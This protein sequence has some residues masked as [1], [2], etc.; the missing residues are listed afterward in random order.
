M[1]GI[2]K[3]EAWTVTR[4]QTGGGLCARSHHHVTQYELGTAIMTKNMGSIDRAVR[5][6][7][8]VV[9]IA[10]AATGTVGWWGYIGIV[11]LVTAIVGICPGLLAVRHQDLQARR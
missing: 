7:V 2:R 4:S 11:P 10:L 5:A 9:L 8:G 6:I 1:R 3:E